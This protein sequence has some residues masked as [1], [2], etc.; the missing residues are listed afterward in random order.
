VILREEFEEA[1]GRIGT[2]FPIAI[3]DTEEG[4]NNRLRD[5]VREYVRQERKVAFSDGCERGVR[6]DWKFKTSIDRLKEIDK[7]LK[8]FTTKEG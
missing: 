4:A 6:T 7:Y 2:D 3:G 5:V 1:L 8:G